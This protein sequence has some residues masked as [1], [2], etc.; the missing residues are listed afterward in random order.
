MPRD[1]SVRGCYDAFVTTLTTRRD[2]RPRTSLAAAGPRRGLLAAVAVLALA[3]FVGMPAGWAAMVAG[4]EGGAAATDST[5]LLGTVRDSAGAVVAGAKVVIRNGHTGGGWSNGTTDS[6]GGYRLE[7]LEPGDFLV[8]VELGDL[9]STKSDVIAI[10]AGVN[11]HDL[12]CPRRELRGRVL[13]PAG[14]PVAGALVALE[15]GGAGMASRERKTGPD[16]TFSF[17]LLDGWY[18][19]F[20]DAPGFRPQP[21]FEPPLRVHGASRDLEIRLQP[22]EPPGGGDTAIRGRGAAIRGRVTGL[23]AAELAE[24]LVSAYPPG[25]GHARVV[26]VDAAGRYRIVD[27]EPG[28]EWGL[29]AEAEAGAKK[30]QRLVSVPLDAGREVEGVDLVFPEYFAVSGRVRQADGSATDH[31]KLTFDDPSQADSRSTVIGPHGQFSIALPSGRYQVAAENRA[32]SWISIAA[33]ARAPLVVSGKPL[34]GVRIRLD[35]RGTIAGRIG[36]AA[37]GDRLNEIVVRAFHGHLAQDGEV[38]DRGHYEIGGLTPGPWV[39]TAWSG[40]GDLVSAKASLPAGAPRASL[41]LSFRPGALT[42]S[43]RLGGFD[44]AAHYLVKL[45]RAEDSVDSHV[46][47]VDGDGTFSRSGLVA[48]I[49]HLEV[50]DSAMPFNGHWPLYTGTVDL[51][52]DRSLVLDLTFPP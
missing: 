24:A 2:L 33:L 26:H 11:R 51:R 49:Y 44:P 42:L 14:Q 23:A 46:I 10:A 37:A 30:V 13:S 43:G 41:D 7:G 20:V 32:A 22:A 40:D 31:D 35:A 21:L 19:L 5:V 17:L 12:L 28:G 15:A 8:W 25:G 36:G 45:E 34:R 47:G 27:L 29:V 50:D 9:I 16:G 39:V 1:A 18:T 52:S 6:Q 4:E 3:L 48:G 38:D